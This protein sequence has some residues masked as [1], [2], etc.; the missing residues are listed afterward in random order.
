MGKRRTYE[1]VYKYF[2]DNG[3]ELL[4][5]TY[6]RGD[7]FCEYIYNGVTYRSLFN[8]VFNG[9][10]KHKYDKFL[11]ES[12]IIKRF[13]HKKLTI[14]ESP[15]VY[16]N[17]TQ[18]IKCTCDLCGQ[19]TEM[20]ADV[21]KNKTQ[22]GCQKCS[23]ENKIY[24]TKKDISYCIDYFN[25]YGYAVTDN[26]YKNART[27][28]NYICDKG[29][30][31]SMSLDNFK[32]GYRC[33]DCFKETNSRGEIEIAKIIDD[34]GIKY[35]TQKTI[36]EDGWNSWL[37]FDFY[38]PDKNMAIEFDGQQHFKPVEYFGGAERFKIDKENSK[39]KEDYCIKYGI[40]LLRIGYS[41][42]PNLNKIIKKY[43]NK[44]F[45]N[46]IRIG[47]EYKIEIQN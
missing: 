31:N 13:K 38:I 45:D 24:K 22:D 40:S 44:K 26:V 28:I 21:V 47:K 10:G 39:K 33:P 25:S 27:K 46:I 30:K 32:R 2:K 7:D 20:R 23:F 19:E 5:K 16:K 3:M 42:K 35:E 4:N 9:T 6:I 41:E 14:V 11:N 1:E 18:N 43:I 8:T 15:F 17:V 12:D 36:K 37:R 29:H 34:M